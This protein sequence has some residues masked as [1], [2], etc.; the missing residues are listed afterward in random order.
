MPSGNAG[1][2][3]PRYWFGVLKK[4]EEE[5]RNTEAIDCNCNVPDN[6]ETFKTPITNEHIS[7]IYV[8]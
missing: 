2:I 3:V 5:K 8:C 6:W 1:R 7:F 4:E